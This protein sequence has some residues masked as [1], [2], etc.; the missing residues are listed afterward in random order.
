MFLNNL[1][2]DMSLLYTVKLGAVVSLDNQMKQLGLPCIIEIAHF[3]VFEIFLLDSFK[4]GSTYY[5]H[6]DCRRGTLNEIVRE[7][8]HVA[9][10]VRR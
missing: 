9:A 1:S 8:I 7:S 5:R 3:L 2:V 4:S 6:H 10:L